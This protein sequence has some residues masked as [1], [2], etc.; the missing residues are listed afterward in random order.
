MKRECSLFF[1]LL[2]DGNLRRTQ[3]TWA[4]EIDRQI[5]QDRDRI[6]PMV[7]HAITITAII[8]SPLREQRMLLCHR[9]EE[10][11]N[12]SGCCC[13]ATTYAVRAGAHRPHLGMVVAD[14]QG[15]IEHDHNARLAMKVGEVGGWPRCEENERCST[16][17]R[18]GS[19]GDESKSF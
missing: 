16:Q 13:V 7:D 12:E 5:R 18:D 3:E 2:N 1:S 14:N 6:N 11:S 4:I 9:I 15:K 10:Q 17:W 8:H 19:R